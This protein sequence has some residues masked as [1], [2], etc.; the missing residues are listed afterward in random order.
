M[1]KSSP[2]QDSTMQTPEPLYEQLRR[3]PDDWD[4][5]AV[6]ADWYE[7]AGQQDIA[8]CLRWSIQHRKRPLRSGSRF[9]WFNAATVMTATD[10]A[11]NIPAPLYRALHGGKESCRDVFRDYDTL[12]AAY[13][14]IY[15]A[16]AEA[17]A[18]GWDT[19]AAPGTATAD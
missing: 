2:T 17:R 18:A 4:T 9:Y 5:R 6:L 13:T 11:S 1:V 8:N 14:D 15:L 3:D 10:P 19:N 7:E 16:W 12:Q